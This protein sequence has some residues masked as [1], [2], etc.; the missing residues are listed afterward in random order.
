MST[1]NEPAG[2]YFWLPNPFSLGSYWSSG[3]GAGFFALDPRMG[4]T[5][6]VPFPA[7]FFP[8]TAGCATHGEKEPDHTE[9]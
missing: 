2:D 8:T 5:A 3:S 6:R 1:K 7:A 4:A 9:A